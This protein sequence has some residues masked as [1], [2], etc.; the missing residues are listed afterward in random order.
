MKCQYCNATDNNQSTV[1][2]CPT[3]LKTRELLERFLQYEKGRLLALELLMNALL[4][5]NPN[6]TVIKKLKKGVDTR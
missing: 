6:P 2:I 4:R 1:T 5:G 3:C